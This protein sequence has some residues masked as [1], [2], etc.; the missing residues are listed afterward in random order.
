MG[1]LFNEGSLNESIPSMPNTP[2]EREDGIN[3][4]YVHPSQYPPKEPQI[5][6]EQNIEQDSLEERPKSDLRESLRSQSSMFCG[7]LY[8]IYIIAGLVSVY[9]LLKGLAGRYG[10]EDEYWIPGLIGLLVSVVSILGVSVFKS[11]CNVLIVLLDDCNRRN[12][13]GNNGQQS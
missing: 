13:E 1:K 7:I 10:V 3:V 11:I 9:F 4:K 12:S 5:S 8:T 2:K 6:Q